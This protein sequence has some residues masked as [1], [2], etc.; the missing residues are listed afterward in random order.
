[1]K[2]ELEKDISVCLV[3][4]DEFTVYIEHPDAVIN[5]K[6]HWDDFTAFAENREDI[7]IGEDTVKFFH[8]GGRPEY[9]NLDSWFEDADYTKEAYIKNLPAYKCFLS[10]LE[11]QAEVEQ[12]NKKVT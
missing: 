9:C 4:E 5:F 12:A 7:E 11:W 6:V 2:N 1:M 3:L 8:H 10:L